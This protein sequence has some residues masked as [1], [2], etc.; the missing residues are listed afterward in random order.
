MNRKL[1]IAA[2]V[3]VGLIVSSCTTS[4]M[5]VYGFWDAE[6]DYG[7]LKTFATVV[8]TDG[9]PLVHKQ[10][11]HLTRLELEN[12]HYR[13]DVES[14]DILIVPG[15]FI[16]QQR[17]YKPPVSIPIPAYQPGETKTTSGWVGGKYVTMTEKT[18]GQVEVGSIQ[19]K[20]GEM[21]T[22]YY[23]AISL[24]F[25]DG[26]AL[27]T[28][29]TVVLIWQGVVSDWGDYPD[30]LMDAPS[31][32]GQLIKDY[33]YRRAYSPSRAVDVYE[34]MEYYP[35]SAGQDVYPYPKRDQ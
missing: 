20:A 7:S 15:Y 18:Q 4:Y 29:D 27:R 28:D 23:R 9:N 2:L 14:P 32:V 13:F 26:R 19:V 11:L 35:D 6:L 17:E 10:I 31:M 33:P 30:V 8:P 34:A 5:Q 16:G 21:V 24:S 12:R 25:I 22:N 1:Q 3:A